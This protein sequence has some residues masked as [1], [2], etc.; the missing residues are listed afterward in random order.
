MDTDWL[1]RAFEQQYY[2]I[3]ADTHELRCTAYHLRYRVYCRE[4]GFEQEK[5][6]PGQLESD[7]FDAQSQHCLL[8]DQRTGSAIGC[9]RIIHPHPHGNHPLTFEKFCRD[10]FDSRTRALVARQRETVGECSRLA[11]AREFR[12][13]SHPRHA[14]GRSAVAAPQPQA[15]QNAY[16]VTSLGLF[17]AANAMFYY[18]DLEYCVAM[19][20]PRL[21]RLLRACGIRFEQ[22]GTLLDYHGRRAPFMI[23]HDDIMRYFKSE[24]RTLMELILDQLHPRSWGATAKGEPL[25]SGHHHPTAPLSTSEAEPLPPSAG[26]HHDDYVDDHR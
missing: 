5:D 1:A 11:V 14:C 7:V 4:F 22:A 19:M 10:A 3:P 15:L 21:A 23:G 9:V 20:E 17:L 13:A 25:F 24:V 16:P 2:L 6:C 26:Q 18:S 12:R 8:M